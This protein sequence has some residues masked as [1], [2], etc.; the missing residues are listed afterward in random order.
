[1]GSVEGP[2]KNERI[3]GYFKEEN[4]CSDAGG[5][6]REFKEDTEAS[7]EAGSAF[8]VLAQLHITCS[9]HSFFAILNFFNKS[10]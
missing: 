8:W 10:K 2:V 7:T 6:G 1:M 9:A 5:R 3:L 4:R